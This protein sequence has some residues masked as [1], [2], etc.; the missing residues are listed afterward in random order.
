MKTNE[1]CKEC[2]ELRFINYTCD[3]CGE[4]ILIPDLSLTIIDTEYDFCSIECLKKFINKD[5]TTKDKRFE[6]GI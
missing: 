2:G 3:S 6:Y 1:T 5:K 4:T